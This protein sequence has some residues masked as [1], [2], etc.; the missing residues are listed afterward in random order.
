MANFAFPGRRR[1]VSKLAPTLARAF[2]LAIAMFVLTQEGLPRVVVAR[3]RPE[4]VAGRALPADLALVLPD[5]LGFVQVRLSALRKTAFGKKMLRELATENAVL[6]QEVKKRLGVPMESIERVTLVIHSPKDEQPV[7]IVGTVEPYDR[8]KILEAVLPGAQEHRLKSASYYTA[9]GKGR[10]AMHFVNDRVYVCG[11]VEDVVQQLAAAPRPDAG[12]P[13]RAALHLA[14]QKHHVLAGAN[15]PEDLLSELNDRAPRQSNQSL[16]M[17]VMQALKPLLEVRS[18]SLTIDVAE[19]ADVRIQLFFPT[20]PKAKA[21]LWPARDGLAVVRLAIRSLAGQLEKEIGVK[22]P[23]SLVKPLESALQAAVI[24]QHG[25]ALHGAFHVPGELAMNAFPGLFR[26]SVQLSRGVGDRGTSAN[27]LRQVALAMHN[28]HDIHGSFPAAA[29]YSKDGKPLLSWR[30]AILPFIEQEN[31]YQQFKLDEPWDSTHNKA[32]LKQMPR[33]YNVSAD[34]A[35][36]KAYATH[37]QVFAGKGSAFDG[38]RG[39]RIGEITDGTSNTIMVIE[40]AEPVPW[41][42]PEDLPFD[43]KKPL[44]KVGGLFPNGFNAAMCDAS[45]RFI[46]NTIKESKL[47]ALVTRNGGEVIGDIDE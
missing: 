2:F 32:L 24:E 10:A 18:A 28:Y 34:G 12:G 31:L 27:N 30:V 7:V 25:A 37:Y 33:T 19:E 26:A 40:G 45:V 47:R 22:N 20:E 44:P 39:R 9:K 23:E 3:D 35:A 38:K 14:G 6:E 1:L 46:K 5:S 42:K 13:L 36:G 11:L 29:T 17:A 8:K 41:T 16:E 43:P 15:L 21:A 4:D